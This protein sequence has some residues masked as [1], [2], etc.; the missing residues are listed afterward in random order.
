[1]LE[2]ELLGAVAH[3]RLQVPV[4]VLEREV[5][6]PADLIEA[7]DLLAEIEVV[8]SLAQRRLELVVV[9]GLGD[10]PV[11]LAAVDG[12]HGHVHL[13]VAGEHHADDFGVSIADRGEQVDAAHVRHALVGHH[14]LGRGLVQ[15]FERLG[16]ARRAQHLHLLVAQQALERLE[17]VH[18][19]VDEENRVLV[20]GP[21]G[22]PNEGPHYSLSSFVPGPR[23]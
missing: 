2:R 13:G 7:L 3:L 5:L 11:D 8:E 18:L 12:V 21:P 17:D 6:L 1:M 15:E 9:P 4:H 23:L 22:G 16:P 10:Q 19:V 14:H 20:H